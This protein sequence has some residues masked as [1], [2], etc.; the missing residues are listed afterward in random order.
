MEKTTLNKHEM[1]AYLRI[2]VSTL[3]NMVARG[4]MPC[5]RIGKRG[6]RRFIKEDVMKA[7]EENSKKWD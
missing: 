4:D 7:L 1:A 3:N 6:D 2:S 5:I